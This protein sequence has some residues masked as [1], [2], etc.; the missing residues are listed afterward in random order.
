MMTTVSRSRMA[1]SI[2]RPR[3]GQ[4]KTTSTT[5]AP[6]EQPGK[7]HAAES[8]HRYDRV[9]QRVLEDDQAFLQA[10]DAGELHKFAVQHFQHAGAGEPHKPGHHEQRDGDAGQ[11]VVVDAAAPIGG[12]PFQLRAEEH[13]Q[14][15]GNP[16]LGGRHADDGQQ[17]AQ[18]VEYGVSF[19]RREHA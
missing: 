2:R 14:H 4:A 7:A 9:L 8:Q 19:D 11:D 5:M 16:E 1:S 15:D 6:V 18:L 3:P 17:L 12:Q 10:L 13:D